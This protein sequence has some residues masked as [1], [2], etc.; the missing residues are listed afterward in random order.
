MAK[1]RSLTPARGWKKGLGDSREADSAGVLA[2]VPVPLGPGAM[3]A[4]NPA[5]GEESR[6]LE[7]RRG[8]STRLRDTV[9]MMERGRV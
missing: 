3:G 4:P 2:L 7:N 1:S 8:T 5:S 6:R 9:K